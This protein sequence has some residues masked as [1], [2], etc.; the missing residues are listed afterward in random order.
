MIDDPTGEWISYE[1]RTMKSTHPG[2]PLS[3]EEFDSAWYLDVNVDVRAAGLDPWEHYV[4]YG[5]HEG[6]LG[7]PL[8]ALELD[9]ILWR[10]FARES[11]A[12]L[13]S[14]LR[15]RKP[16]ERAAA[17]W[18]FA[19]H[20]ASKGKWHTALGAIRKFCDAPSEMQV[21]SHPGPWLLAIQ[22]A[23]RLGDFDAARCW[24][25][26]ARAR[27]PA[28]GNLA[29]A[30][31]ELALAEK[32]SGE[33]ISDCL[34]AVYSGT[35][36]EPICLTASG[37]TL[38][39][40]LCT[41]WA[42]AEVAD[43]P[44][45]SI[46]V[47]VYNA[48]QTLRTCLRS[49]IAQSWRNLEI[50]VVDDCSTDGTAMI[51][52]E[53]AHR[54]PR[55]RLIRHPSN[56]GAYVS[57][58]TGL[59]V[60]SGAFYTVHDADDWSHPQKI[61][62][63][64]RPLLDR[65]ELWATFSHML[66][67]D[68]DLRMSVWRMEEGWVYRN[69]SSLMLRAEVRDR[70]GFWDRVRMGADTEYYHRVRLAFG[71]DSIADVHPGVP[72]SFART[73]S[74]SLTL[75]ST[76]HLATQFA[77]ARRQYLNAADDLHRR[78]IAD[79]PDQSCIE[80]RARALYLESRPQRRPFLAPVEARPADPF[81]PPD[82]YGKV[83]TS[84][85]FDGGWYLRCYPD[86]LKADVDP[87]R[88][89]LDYGAREDRDPGPLFANAAWRQLAE[90]DSDTI[91]LLEL[92][93]DI[94]LASPPCFSGALPRTG[95]PIALVFAHAAER[96][97]FGAERS[98]LITLERLASGYAGCA[99]DPVVVLPSAVNEWYLQQVRD[100]AVAVEILPQLWRHRFR[101]VPE[102]T[103]EAIRG[104]IRRY[105]PAQ[106]HV[107]TIVLDAPSLAARQEGCQCVIHV[108]ELPAQD[109]DL[110]RLLGDTPAG[111][112]RRILAEADSF[113]A[114]SQAVADWIG[115]PQRTEIWQNS[116]DPALFDLP[117]SPEPR[118][119]LALV[120][121]NRAKK[122]I[123]DLVE[124][125]QKVKRLEEIDQV[126]AFRRC[127]FLLIGP[128]T[129]DLD[130]LGPLPE[131]IK[132]AGYAPDAVG[133]M[134]QCD[135]VLI[136]SRVAESFGRTALESMAAGRPVICYD[137]GTPPTFITSGK[138]GFV[139]PADDTEA[140]AMAVMALSLARNQMM[141]MSEEA[142]LYSQ[143]KLEEMAR[144]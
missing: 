17:G 45:V 97:I 91:P 122:G 52:A 30:R 136:L 82:D 89:Y 128:S 104:V 37:D 58:N 47:P 98:L 115:C 12:E 35:G 100:R 65:P 40:R 144:R 28:N 16:R 53:E 25:E 75:Q 4:Q 90:L 46:I 2:L 113:I 86:V 107:N 135:A 88:H 132:H 39:D 6:R 77:G 125:A 93:N 106:V 108:R 123:A 5:Y 109:P 13:R 43:G 126:S 101:P 60:A 112:R 20:A 103:V 62:Q 10:G 44:M 61:E 64:V 134:K 78:R 32:A 63:Q 130:A 72:L 137:R 59:M 27:F 111:L 31:L 76:T 141:R 142:R 42:P 87:V 57:R 124:I 29:A 127:R 133:A 18:I 1:K 33:V 21:I 19:R 50:I 138:T 129:P 67:A 102:Q 99:F 15:S 14:L 8:R 54:D 140:A 23:A 139:V 70:L 73:S 56:E 41:T 22:A 116:I 80:A 55:I 68:D 94:E 85:Y 131:N 3:E 83:A 110:C 49:L 36:L 95:R 24:L 34:A 48:E 120:S 84:P 71:A 119:R 7:A 66:R 11:E 117:F 9:H 79:L 81:D 38:F 114:N 143:R 69:T 92:G 96:T 118:L 105:R 51:A 121:S 26:E 74:R